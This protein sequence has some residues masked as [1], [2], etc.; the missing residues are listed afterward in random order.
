[1][2][3]IAQ[4]EN[5]LMAPKPNTKIIY[6]H[7]QLERRKKANLGDKDDIGFRL[8]ETATTIITDDTE[9]NDASGADLPMAT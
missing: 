6:E 9:T 8:A 3:F 2:K 4:E 7:Q 1:V 5:L